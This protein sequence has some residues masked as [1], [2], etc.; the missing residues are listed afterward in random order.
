[1]RLHFSD[2]TCHCLFALLTVAE[3]IVLGMVIASSR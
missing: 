2:W 3:L 1:M